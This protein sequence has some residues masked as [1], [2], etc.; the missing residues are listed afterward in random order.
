[1]LF[2][3]TSS[4]L[5]KTNGFQEGNG[6]QKRL[7]PPRLAA[8][9]PEPC[10][11]TNSAIWA[12]AGHVAGPQLFQRAFFNALHDCR[13]CLRRGAGRPSIGRTSFELRSNR[14]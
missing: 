6:A 1:M 5:L 3:M 2:S 7:E 8:H 9:G 12:G 11:S 13:P 4:I 14:R 10:A